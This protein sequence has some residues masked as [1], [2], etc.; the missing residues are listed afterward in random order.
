MS[1]HNYLTSDKCARNRQGSQTKQ[2]G[3][4]NQ[5]KPNKTKQQRPTYITLLKN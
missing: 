1:M 2:N 3:Q 4:E 5:T